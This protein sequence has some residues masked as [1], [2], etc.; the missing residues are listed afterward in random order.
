MKEIIAECGVSW[1]NL[2]EAKKLITECYRARADAVKFQL[3]DKTAI[4][5]SRFVKHLE[6]TRLTESM[7]KEL[8]NHAK[9]TDIEIFFT[10]M[11]LD[12]V[13]ICESLG[14]ERYKVRAK[15]AYW[16]ELLMKIRLTDKPCYVSRANY[17]FHDP[18][19]QKNFYTVYYDI[20]RPTK[21]LDVF[22]G[23]SNLLKSDGYSC[24]CTK[25]YVPM[26]VMLFG[27]VDYIEVHVALDANDKTLPDWKYSHSPVDL[28]ELC[29]F[30]KMLN[31]QLFYS[32]A[33]YEM[34]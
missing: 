4:K 18:L 24:H 23:Y 30:K 16:S 14:V 17:K 21:Y 1:H 34:V 27:G 15:D 8:V 26:Q 12:A 22:R 20:N 6:V 11:Y 10:P 29:R 7:A 32:R 28:L 13:D 33:K 31:P 3:Y 25:M 9:K 2:D 5:N 19:K